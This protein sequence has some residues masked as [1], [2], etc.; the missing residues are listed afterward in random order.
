M[1]PDMSLFMK[2]SC[3]RI[4]ALERWLSGSIRNCDMGLLQIPV[5]ALPIVLE[6]DFHALK[7]HSG[8]TRGSGM[9]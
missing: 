9:E 3:Y 8:H 2:S 5:S 1:D 6:M 7:A 4:A